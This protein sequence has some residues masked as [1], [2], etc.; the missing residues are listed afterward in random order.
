MFI[1]NVKLF[2][3]I[4]IKGSKKQKTWKVEGEQKCE[5]LE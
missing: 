3:C 4:T 5:A 2:N 1:Y